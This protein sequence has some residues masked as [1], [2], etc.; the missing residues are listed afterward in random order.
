MSKGLLTFLKSHLTRA[1]WSLR[2]SLCARLHQ[3][4]AARLGWARVMSPR[5]HPILAEVH[6]VPRH[7]HGRE[8]GI[9]I[10]DSCT[11]SD[12]ANNPFRRIW[13]KVGPRWISRKQDRVF[14]PSQ[15]R[16]GP[17]PKMTTLSKKGKR[18]GVSTSST[19]Q[20]VQPNPKDKWKSIS[21]WKTRGYHM[22]PRSR[23]LLKKGSWSWNPFWN[24]F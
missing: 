11:C 5:G 15:W 23:G 19:T 2:I 12:Q 13:K 16:R 24:T 14:W 18:K 4:L 1:Q 21:L 3:I 10:G 7:I 6:S 9:F 22:C 8:E 20:E 17:A